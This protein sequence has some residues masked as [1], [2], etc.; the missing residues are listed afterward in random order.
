[1]TPAD[2][3]DAI[4]IPAAF[5]GYACTQCGS[6]IEL[7]CGDD[8][9]GYS[10]IHGCI[11]GA[12]IPCGRIAA[13][14]EGVIPTWRD[15]GDPVVVDRIRADHED[16]VRYRHCITSDAHDPMWTRF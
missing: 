13:L 1:M 5:T 12:C 4:P 3:K 14:V 15:A 16:S 11:A 9:K 2:P 10:G 8:G 7:M 6:P